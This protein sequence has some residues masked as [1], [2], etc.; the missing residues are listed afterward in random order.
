MRA[1][2]LLGL[3]VL[4]FAAVFAATS[5]YYRANEE[6]S[7]TA[8]PEGTMKPAGRLLVALEENPTVRLYS[9]A[10]DGSE[11]RLLTNAQPAEGD[12][13]VEA[14]PDWSAEAQRIVFTRYAARGSHE[15][16]PKIWTMARDGTDLVQ[17]TRGS[18]ADFLPAWSPDGQMIAFTRMLRDRSEIF[19]MNADGSSVKQLTRDRVT[20]DQAPAWSPDGTR[21]AYSSRE[22]G[23]QN[24]VIV[25]TDGSEAMQLTDGPFEASG[26]AWSPDG[27]QIAFICDADLCLVGS[28]Q[29]S[30]PVQLLGTAAPEFSLRWSPDGKWIAFVRDPGLLMMLEVETKKTVRVPVEGDTYTFSWGPA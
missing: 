30:R 6:G 2:L 15:E 12:V 17:L 18:H 27:K 22:A 8:G 13:L 4:S 20:D 14:H 1:R 19:L 28:E 29:G 7:A 9:V 25:N 21:I 24:L 11:A 26:P 3:P 16:P 23:E 5:A 10:V